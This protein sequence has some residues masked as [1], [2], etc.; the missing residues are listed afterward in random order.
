LIDANE[1]KTELLQELSHYQITGISLEPSQL[2]LR[3]DLTCGPDKPD[4]AIEMHNIAQI[5]LSKTPDD[6]DSCYLIGKVAITPYQDGG[7]AIL[8]KLGYAFYDERGE[9][10]ASTT[11]AFHIRIEGDMCLNVV[12]QAT[13]SSKR[14]KQTRTK[15]E[16]V[17]NLKIITVQ[18]NSYPTTL[19]EKTTNTASRHLSGTRQFELRRRQL[20]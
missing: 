4:I 20:F 19:N 17:I 8:T 10:M 12:C 14:F 9:V 11:K 18:T 16:Q 3:V 2:W 15:L 5:S 13:N 6:E 1:I 7:K